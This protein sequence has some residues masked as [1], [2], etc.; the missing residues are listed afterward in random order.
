MLA[1]ARLVKN[2]AAL[3][4]SVLFMAPTAEECGLLGSKFYAADPLPVDGKK[5][6]PIAA[7]AFDVGNVWGKTED[8]AVL[9]YGKSSL[10]PILQEAAASRG[11]R[12]IPD[13]Q[14]K[15]GLFYRSDHWSFVRFRNS[16]MLVFLWPRLHWQARHLLRRGSWSI[17]QDRVPQASWH[18]QV[19]LEYGRLVVSSWIHLGGGKA[20]G[21]TSWLLPKD[22]HGHLSH[23]RDPQRGQVVDATVP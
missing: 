14:P 13:Q 6:H 21:D 10:D 11:L 19:S 16:R 23:G 20:I 18:L 4:R 3:S 17:H 12:I 7:F 2:S 8:I 5:L 15:M 1:T 22:P 9:G